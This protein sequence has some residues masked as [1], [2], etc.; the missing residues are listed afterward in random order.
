MFQTWS[1]LICPLKT[2]VKRVKIKQVNIFPSIQYVVPYY[3]S[4]STVSIEIVIWYLSKYRPITV[5]SQN[6]F[7]CWYNVYVYHKNKKPG[8]F[9]FPGR[10]FFFSLDQ[11]GVTR[12]CKLSLLCLS[13]NR[14][15]TAVITVILLRQL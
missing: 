3:S 12:N 7:Y 8:I 10:K 13:D 11:Y 6:Y 15:T 1:V 5:I 9:I 2:R 4:F 14:S